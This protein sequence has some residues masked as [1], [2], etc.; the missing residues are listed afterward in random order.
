IGRNNTGKSQLLD[1]VEAL[2][3]GNLSGRR[4]R[5]RCSGI[6]DAASLQ[7]AFALNTSVGELGGRHWEDHG[8]KLQNVPVNWELDENLNASEP[9]FPDSFDITSPLGERS[10]AARKALLQQVLKNVR[11]PLFGTNYRRLLADRDI[12]PETPSNELQLSPAGAG[13]TNIIRRYLVTSNPR[14]PRE[15]IQRD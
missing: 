8:A 3:A 14:F 7:T 5:Y 4:W 15:V 6:L 1:L 11:H 12:R 13:T 10:T 2:C 9:I